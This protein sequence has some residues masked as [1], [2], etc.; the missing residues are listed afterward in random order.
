MCGAGA[1]D[2]G[3]FDLG[4]FFLYFLL[5]V[6]LSNLIESK[7]RTDG[8]RGDLSEKIFSVFRRDGSEKD[9]AS[10]GLVGE[11]AEGI[12]GGKSACEKMGTAFSSE[13]NTISSH[14][15]GTRGE[16]LEEGR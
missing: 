13:P 9:G 2:S 1:R 12:R 14:I 11:E 6:T 10:V 8:V 3:W 15:G 7:G 5:T 4:I 16:V